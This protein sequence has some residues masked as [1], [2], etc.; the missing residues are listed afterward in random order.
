MSK[1]IF[2]KPARQHYE[3]QTWALAFACGVG[4]V[5]RDI[6]F[7]EVYEL[8]FSYVDNLPNLLRQC[9]YVVAE[10]YLEGEG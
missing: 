1:M 8:A 7:T 5:R 3:K 9:P 6:D 2:P 10:A 4:S